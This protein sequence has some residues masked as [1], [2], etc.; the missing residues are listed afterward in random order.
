VYARS[1]PG[2]QCRRRRR[3]QP[4]VNQYN[5]AWKV[6]PVDTINKF[7]YTKCAHKKRKVTAPTQF[8]PN[9]IM[10]DPGANKHHDVCCEMHCSAMSCAWVGSGVA[11]V[12]KIAAIGDFSHGS[13]FARRDGFDFLAPN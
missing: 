3:A 10:S 13:T 9:L 5:P 6:V 12:I 4:K 8:R 1:A 11:R 7:K 2:Q